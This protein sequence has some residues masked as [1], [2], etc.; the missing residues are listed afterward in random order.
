MISDS[1]SEYFVG[2]GVHTDDRMSSDQIRNALKV[3]SDDLDK[4]GNG[5]VKMYIGI[6]L[7][8]IL[9]LESGVCGN[10]CS[11]NTSNELSKE[12]STST[13]SAIE[14]DPVRAMELAVFTTELVLQR[15]RLGDYRQAN[16]SEILALEL[17][18]DMTRSN[19]IQIRK[20]Q[21]KA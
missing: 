19:L 13:I 17:I 18:I 7:D 16:N 8:R 3:Y 6:L 15:I 1:S 20:A 14:V 4:V 2:S 11:R 5:Q 12:Q 10:A 21:G 9:E